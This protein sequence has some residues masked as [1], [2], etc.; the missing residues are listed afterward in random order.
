MIILENKNIRENR[1][2]DIFREYNFLI[3]FNCFNLFLNN[4]YINMENG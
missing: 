4:H 2:R 3:I 1:K